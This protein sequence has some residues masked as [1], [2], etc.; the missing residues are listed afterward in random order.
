MRPP[1]GAALEIKTLEGVGE[2]SELGVPT[3]LWRGPQLTQ[4][5]CRWLRGGPRDSASKLERSGNP[6]ERNQRA[7]TTDKSARGD[8]RNFLPRTP[9]R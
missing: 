7:V 8:Q 9:S 2:W 4:C 5:R 3:G 6:L 1:S